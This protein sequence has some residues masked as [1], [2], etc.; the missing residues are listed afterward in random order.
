MHYDHVIV[1]RLVNFIR[2]IHT[3]SPWQD[4]GRFFK[5]LHRIIPFDN[6]A[7]FIK[8]DPATSRILPSSMT[9][10]EDEAD[11]MRDHNQYY[12]K[13]KQPIVA[14]IV[15]KRLR[16]FHVQNALPQFLSKPDS[17]EYRVDFWEKH[18]K[19]FSY[20]QYFK[21]RQGLFS[22][23]LTRSSRSPDFSEE[24]EGL[25]NML[26]PHMELILS[27]AEPETPTLFADPKGN[28]VCVDAAV[29]DTLKQ[30]PTLAKQFQ[31]ALPT[32]IG[33]FLSEPFKPL[34]VEIGEGEQRYRCTVSPAGTARLPL[35]RISWAPMAAPAGF[36]ENILAAFCRRYPFSPREKQV[37]ALT[38][39]GKQRK[40]MA[41]ALGLSVETVKE[42]LSGVYRKTG[43]EGKG[44]L[45]AKILSQTHPPATMEVT[46]PFIISD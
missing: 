2:E 20:A 41:Q 26:L 27:A 43:V 1:K 3:V 33:W 42:Y 34:W 23:Y 4:Q 36:S 5:T 11:V 31:Q 40:E 24:E 18:R 38:A 22:L 10:W 17:E 15:N 21:T 39:A 8:V 32:W 19:R 35:F 30:D 12:W 37:L 46:P 28:I 44:E 13:F 6:S 7:A 25:L 16:S 14:E 9:L 45:L 29:D